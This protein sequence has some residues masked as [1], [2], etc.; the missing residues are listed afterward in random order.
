MEIVISLK[1]WGRV[2]SGVIDLL[3]LSELLLNPVEFFFGL[4]L[5]HQCPDRFCFFSFFWESFFMRKCKVCDSSMAC[6]YI[7]VLRPVQNFFSS[8]AHVSS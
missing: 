1:M 2:V 3:G 4:H 6:S 7:S 8:A 5:S